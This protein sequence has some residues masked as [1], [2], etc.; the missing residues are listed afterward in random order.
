[1]EK[2]KKNH[3]TISNPDFMDHQL[4]RYAN[5]KILHP[6]LHILYIFQFDCEI[7]SCNWLDSNTWKDVWPW[8]WNFKR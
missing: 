1:M 8:I 3:P 6:Q 2:K 5:S 7:L 4:S